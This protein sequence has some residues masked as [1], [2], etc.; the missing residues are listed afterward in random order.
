MIKP[1]SFDIEKFR[2]RQHE[3]MANAEAEVR[4]ARERAGVAID[5]SGEEFLRAGLVNAIGTEQAE[6]IME[7]VDPIA[8]REIRR[9]HALVEKLSREGRLV[10]E[11][12][13]EL[14]YSYRRVVE[15]RAK[16]GC[17]K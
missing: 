11:I 9:K 13:Q 2:S 16:L 10:R 17:G 4:A 12:A 5:A 7:I 3:M 15:I 1:G 14:N 6:A 8:K